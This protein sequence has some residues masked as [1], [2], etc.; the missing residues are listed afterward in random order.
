M[1]VRRMPQHNWL[2]IIKFQ[3][4]WFLKAE[5][6]CCLLGSRGDWSTEKLCVLTFSLLPTL[7]ICLLCTQFLRPHNGWQSA[8]CWDW[9]CS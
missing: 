4:L 3:R 6:A 7:S 9:L 5:S 1:T 8:R 2:D